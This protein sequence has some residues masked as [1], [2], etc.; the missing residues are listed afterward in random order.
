MLAVAP[1]KSAAD[2]AGAGSAALRP[3]SHGAAPPVPGMSTAAR[4]APA[5][6]SYDV[7]AI[8]DAMEAQDI[9]ASV[10]GV[11]GDAIGHL[12]TSARGTRVRWRATEAGWE[13]G[14]WQAQ[15]HTHPRIHAS[16][17]PRIQAYTVARVL[18]CSVPRLPDC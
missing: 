11:V 15:Q 6:A 16:T 5:E 1:R 13:A 18:G 14:V 8:M 2:V 17:H 10:I 4:A 7:L 9:D 12:A 3:V